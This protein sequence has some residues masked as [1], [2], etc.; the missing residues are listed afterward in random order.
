MPTPKPGQIRCPTCHQPT[1]MAAFCT[2][3]GAAIPPGAQ[4]RPRGMDRQELD[5]RIRQRRPGEGRLRRGT[6]GYDRVDAAPAQF[7]PFERE[8]EDAQAVRE[9]AE[10]PARVDNLPPGVDRP[11]QPE[12]QPAY[13]REGEPP[14]HAESDARVDDGRYEPDGYGA[15]EPYADEGYDTDE[16]YGAPEDAYPYSEAYAAEPRRGGSGMLPI[17]GFAA[18]AILALGIGAALAGILGG[19]GIAAASATPTTTVSGAASE[20]PSAEPTAS[21]AQESTTPEPTEG[22]IT[23]PDGAVLTVQPCATK[24]MSF[25]GCDV[26]GS[27]ISRPTMW[28]WVGFKDAVGSDEITLELQSGG[29]T[30]DQ[31]EQE[32]RSVVSCPES[33]SGYLIGAAYKD[34]EPGDY[35]LVVRRNDD[36]ADSATFS[37]ES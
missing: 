21:G 28:V 7:V 19:G 14:A 10:E 5:A 1:P 22:P 11:P 26:D 27:T 32:L 18:L 34:L 6:G 36:F 31:Q 13:A 24:E 37:V 3:C 12:Q 25:E 23:F 15:A 20:E 29:Q 8:P 30:I 33:C 17:I 16:P 4:A 35:E 9:P 2:Q